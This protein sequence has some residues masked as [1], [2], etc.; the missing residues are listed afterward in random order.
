MSSEKVFNDFEFERR[1]FCEE[2]PSKYFDGARSYLIVQSYFLATDGYS[3]RIRVQARDAYLNMS[4]NL[5][6]MEVT[7]KYEDKFSYAFCVLKGPA[8]G[9]T[10]YES[11]TEIDVNVALEM[12]RRNPD[13]AVVKNRYYV[14]IGEDGWILDLFGGKNYPLIIAECERSMPVVNLKIPAFCTTEI[15]DEKRFGND[16]LTNYPF[17]DWQQDYVNELKEKGVHFS[18]LFGENT[19]LSDK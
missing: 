14:W 15:T 16:A 6:A 10:R 9:G 1:F 18:D 4:E 7:K 17:S 12:I 8:V 11:V 19:F 5:D 3:I 13:K 2:I